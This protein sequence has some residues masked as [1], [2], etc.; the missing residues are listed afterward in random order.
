MKK[1]FTDYV[2]NTLFAVFP[3]NSDIVERCVCRLRFT[4]YYLMILL[5]NN[6]PPLYNVTLF[7]THLCL[8][9]PKCTDNLFYYPLYVTPC[10]YSAVCLLLSLGLFRIYQSFVRRRLNLWLNC[11]HTRRQSLIGKY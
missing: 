11:H 3:N 10:C 6:G 1:G 7:V 2:R 4:L 9:R 8:Q 5:R